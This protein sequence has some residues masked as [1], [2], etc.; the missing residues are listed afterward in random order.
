MLRRYS[1]VAL[2]VLSLTASFATA[3]DAVKIGERVGKLKLTD[4]RYLP[5]TLDDFGTKKAYVL[6]FTNSTCPLVKRYLPT[7]QSLEKDY[8]AKDVQF[9]AVNSADA[10]SIITTATQ[11]VQHD[12]E[13]PFVKDFGGVCAKTLGVRR[14]PEVI[15]LDA[16][17][18]LVYRG[19]IDDQ[20]RLGGVR[21][22]PTSND[23]K[24]AL[25]ALLAGRKVANAETEVDGCPIT[26][27]APRKPRDVTYA[28]HVAPILKKHC[29]E[30][31]RAGGSAPFALTSFKQASSQAET[32]AEVVTTQR[33]PPWFASHEFGPFVN[34]R[35]LS[36]EEREIVVDWARSG[37]AQGDA[38]KTPAAAKAPEGKWLID[39]P[40]L[41][42]ETAELKLPAKGDIPYQY[43]I[44]LH[45]FNEDTWVQNVQIV[46]DN[47]RALHHCNMAFGDLT[48]KFSEANFITGY[49]PGGEPMNLEPGIAFCI[50]KGSILALQMHFVATGKPETCRVAVGLRYPREV[51]QKR[52]RNIQLNTNKFA[53]APGAPA[54]KITAS[55]VLDRDVIGVGMF[56][57]M[58]LRG[59][60]MTFIAHRPQKKADTLL[61]IPNYSFAW[62][63]PYRWEP[64]KTRFE[65]GTRL[66]C[67][68][69]FDNSTFNPYN[70]DAK[71][72]VRFGPQT[73]HE[74]MY[75]FFFYT[76]ADQQL[77]LTIDPKTGTPRKVEKAK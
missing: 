20:Y 73:Y 58:H 47:L 41:V 19:R 62:Q 18:R 23:L 68:A 46:P 12:V 51:V 3:Q 28:E 76:D 10:D 2:T 50:P 72:T 35:G 75:G 42:L 13:F 15:V 45:V 60:D 55:R 1:I 24:D 49:V 74:M 36:D 54:H 63:L 26:F 59:K 4:I 48:L 71:A 65:K 38:K 40:D 61:V 8:R 52:L 16:D 44:L 66:E 9:L 43:T 27:A 64:G 69:H 37:A 11:A 31:H 22:E 5:R 32:L 67:V 6:V 33:M 56:S 70:P 14:T 7:L 57:H 29:W 25:E 39:T 17:K 53:I 77:G 21:K 30:C 34:R